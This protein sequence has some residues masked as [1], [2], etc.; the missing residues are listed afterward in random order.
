VAS[1]SAVRSGRFFAVDAN[2]LFSRC[3]TNLV[4]ATELLRALIHLEAR[5]PPPAGANRIGSE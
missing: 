5:M 2:R 3:T 4:E 1:L